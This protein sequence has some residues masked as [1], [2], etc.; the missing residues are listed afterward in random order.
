V[1]CTLPPD[2]VARLDVVTGFEVGFP[3]DFIAQTSPWVFGDANLRLATDK[4]R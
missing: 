4:P 1:D 2:A 3:T